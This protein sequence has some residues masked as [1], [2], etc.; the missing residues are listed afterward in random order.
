ML[1]STKDETLFSL[2]LLYNSDTV[3]A[4]T[5]NK[6]LPHLMETRIKK[7]MKEG[8]LSIS[9]MRGL[10]NKKA[11]MSVAH[12]LTEDNPTE[13]KQW[14]QTGSRWLDSIVC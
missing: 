6:S 7:K 3:T 1:R 2:I 9:D 10:I 4:L 8:N 5:F 14:I 13:V 12:N 11:G